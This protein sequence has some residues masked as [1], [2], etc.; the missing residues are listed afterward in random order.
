MIIGL[1]DT[2]N[3]DT[4]VENLYNRRN[5]Q[6]N[7]ISRHILW[8]TTILQPN[9]HS[10]TH[11]CSLYS[12]A[13]NFLLILNG[14]KAVRNEFSRYTPIYNSFSRFMLYITIFLVS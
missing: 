10:S 12:S 3:N 8:Q 13:N 6:E 9:S 11:G 4:E 5:N 7:L 14:A 2:G 1:K